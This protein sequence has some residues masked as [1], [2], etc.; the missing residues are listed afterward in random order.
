[1][2][3][4]KNSVK[5]TEVIKKQAAS[6]FKTDLSLDE[7]LVKRIIAAEVKVRQG[8]VLKTSGGITVSALAQICVLYEG[9]GGQDVYESGV[10]FS[11]EIPFDGEYLR[12][13]LVSL[14]S[15]EVKIAMGAGGYHITAEILAEAE[16]LV[17]KNLEFVSDVE[18]AICK[19]TN[20][21]ALEYKLSCVQNY[22]QEEQ[23]SF[24][25]A[26]KRLLCADENVRVI[27]VQCG[28]SV[29][30][31]DAE[32]GGDFTFLTENGDRVRE[33]VWFPL[34]FELEAEGV[35]PEM[36]VSGAAVLCGSAYKMESSEQDNSSLMTFGYNI[37]FFC[38]VF[39]QNDCERV[40]DCFS[41]VSEAQISRTEISCEVGRELICLNGKCLGEGVC[42]RDGIIKSVLSS[43]VYGLEF[44]VS[45]GKA[46]FS[47]VVKAVVLTENA[48]GVVKKAVCEL[49]FSLDFSIRYSNVSSAFAIA[50][51]T[52]V[53]EFD[54]KCVLESELLFNAVCLDKKDESVVETVVF[55]EEKPVDDC[56]ISMIFVKKG[57]DAWDVCKKAGVSERVLKQQNPS[58][59]FPADKDSVISVYKRIEI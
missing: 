48:D 30:I 37:R 38:D 58:I 20:F 35:T 3:I 24:Q 34:R 32:V 47:G 45:A 57:D 21:S 42:E 9:E 1:M 54:G 11:L 17:L 55:G 31:F 52:S 59:E 39:E 23:K 43:C 44:S 46:S 2:D 50:K 18:G 28:P 19:K 53:K 36:I 40:E 8:G 51:S 29:V 7:S 22:E 27:N 16:F 14:S 41:L 12:E 33:S 15:G 13:P 56:A 26:I 4:I 25:Y 6:G 10:D 5:Q 49:P